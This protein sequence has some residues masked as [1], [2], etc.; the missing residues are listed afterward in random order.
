MVL[1][2]T[3]KYFLSRQKRNISAVWLL[4][5]FQIGNISYLFCSKFWEVI[6]HAAFQYV[7]MYIF[8]SMHSRSNDLPALYFKE[9]Y[10]NDSY[11][12]F[13][14]SLVSRASIY[15]VCILIQHGYYLTIIHLSAAFIVLNFVKI[16]Y[17]SIQV[18]GLC[19][20]FDVLFSI[21]YR[22]KAIYDNC[23][24]YIKCNQKTSEAQ[25]IYFYKYW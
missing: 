12:S 10:E 18:H 15:K 3:I 23:F 20:L 21:S 2:V 16:F 17:R 7:G 11:T 8:F 22:L 14:L 6:I 9:T 24:I 4:S 25:E 13:Y 1:F 5:Y 19:Q